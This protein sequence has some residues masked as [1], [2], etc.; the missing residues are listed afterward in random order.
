VVTLPGAGAIWVIDP[1]SLAVKARL[2]VP[3]VRRAVAAPA[4]S[5]AAAVGDGPDLQLVPLDGRP[6]RTVRPGDFGR[7]VG[8]RKPALTPDGKY[9]VAT[10]GQTGLFRF[11][12][13]AAGPALAFEEA[14]PAILRGA[15]GEIQTS[16]DGQL[17]G[18][19]SAEGNHDPAFVLRTTGQNS[20][21]ARW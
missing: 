1:D 9:L 7:P 4:L 10:D 5:L 13:Q 8:L 20:C 19:P 11:A 3:G 6:P 12:V 14:T 2:A 15:A 21:Q 17:V 16:P 18:L